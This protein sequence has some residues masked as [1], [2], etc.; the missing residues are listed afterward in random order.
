MSTLREFIDRHTA[1][2]EPL[3]RE[4]ALAQWDFETTGSPEAMDRVA[5]LETRYRK[6]Y[7]RADEYAYL[8][9]IATDSDP[10]DARILK[11][12]K[13]GYRGGQMSDEAIARLVKT[14][15]E[16]QNIYG[17]FRSE[18]NGQKVPDNTLVDILRTGEDKQQR[19]AA[20]E[21][22]KQIGPHVADLVRRLAEMRNE[23]AVKL[24]FTDFYSK[25]LELQEIGVDELFAL[26]GRLDTASEPLFTE[27]K[28]GYDH[29]IA[30]RCG[31]LPDEE[32]LPWNYAD[33]FFQGAPP[34]KL[35]L[36]VYF[37][38]KNIEAVTA[39][40]F[41]RI[42][43]PIEDLLKRS[44]LYERDGKSQH[45]FCTDIDRL[46]DVRI[47]CNIR[48]NAR[49]MG[50]MLHE[51]GHG[52]YD[53]FNDASLPWLLRT[54]SHILTT[55]AI[56][57][58]MGGLAA[59]KDWLME[60]AGVAPD[61]AAQV[62][63]VAREEDRM[64]KLIFTRWVLVMT[65]FERAMYADPAQDLN[66]LWWGLVSRYQQVRKP[67]GRDM[68][69][70]ATKLHVAL[71]PAYYHN[72]LLGDLYACQ[73]R[74]YILSQVIESGDMRDMVTSRRL[75]EFLVDGLFKMGARYDWKDTIERTTGE[76]L[77]PR[78]FVDELTPPP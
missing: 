78:Y 13:D 30:A 54:P 66:A 11:L 34:G 16:I 55:E 45:A 75:G 43:L 23:E 44:D 22:S 49:W 21:A 50:T 68:P 62:A 70:W 59:N 17:N 77:N 65:A 42:G 61:E 25:S 24:E 57:I 15:T 32:S 46:G 40:F 69:D 35:D 29:E 27:M 53:K 20:W 71:A 37:K 9:G 10:V 31:L 12:L 76:P 47:V 28:A 5:D 56:A 1:E 38:D 48:P 64:Q 52:V 58:F 74:H 51:Y 63:A 18:L 19:Q 36:D 60:Y 67:E 2:I 41:E 26:L 33:P 3:S 72:Y 14:E 7:A 4:T 39:R 8:K 6:V 73:L